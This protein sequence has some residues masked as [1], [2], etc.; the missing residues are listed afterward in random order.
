LDGDGRA[1][2][3]FSSGLFVFS[4]PPQGDADFMPDHMM[5]PE[6]FYFCLQLPSFSP[7]WHVHT[8]VEV[9]GYLYYDMC[10]GVLLEI[11]S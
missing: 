10:R 7:F 3:V 1:L 8:Y 5:L 11:S 2:V 6:Y 4:F 9:F